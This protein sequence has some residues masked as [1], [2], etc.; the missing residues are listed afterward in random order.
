VSAISRERVKAALALDVADRPPFGLWGHDYLKE[1]SPGDLAA[2]TVRR[3]RE[4]GWDFIKFQPRASCFAEAF[5]AQY[6]P[7]GDRLKGPVFIASP[8]ESAKSWAELS[9]ADASAG[10]LADQV[11]SIKKVAAEVG[12]DISVIQTVF[13]PITVAGHMVGR[14]SARVVQD[15][16]DH[17]KPMTKALALIAET[18][19][20]FARRSIE[21]GAAGIFY[22]ISGYASDDVMTQ[23]E[24]TDSLLDFDHQILD[25][26]PHQSW[27]NV[28]HLCGSH[29]H[30]NLAKE[31]PANATS[32]SIHD[33]GNPSLKSGLEKS[34]RAVMGGIDQRVTLLK[35]TQD[36]VLVEV[37]SAG[38]TAEGKG[39]LISPGCSVPPEI[40]KENLHWISK[41]MG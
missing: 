26:L 19:I 15:L 8:I 20:D 2:E 22:A 37:T 24:Y 28:I 16:R 7:S 32:W 41:S 17:P 4:F 34:S 39:I 27:F 35:G 5:G 3:G 33:K 36:E 9:T 18:L 30:F 12:P 25:T 38:A 1:W 14:D 13:S 40:P 10:P 31:L 29:I 11:T 21:A 23:Q 6:R